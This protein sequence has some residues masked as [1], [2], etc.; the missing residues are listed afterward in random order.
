MD[1]PYGGTP[2]KLPQ[3]SIKLYNIPPCFFRN[4]YYKES[5][6]GK[7]YTHTYVEQHF[8]KHIPQETS[9]KSSS[10]SKGFLGHIIL[11]ST[12]CY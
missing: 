11:E 9:A 7:S 8:S 1:I 10:M 4:F 2:F 5:G 3:F 12:D 6:F